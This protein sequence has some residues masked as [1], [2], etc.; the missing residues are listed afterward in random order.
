VRVLNDAAAYDGYMRRSTALSPAFTD[1][2]SV[3]AALQQARAFGPRSMVRGAVA[4]AAVAALQNQAFVAALRDAGNTPEHRDQMVGYILTNPVYLYGFKGSQE[5]AAL[6]QSALAPSALKLYGTGRIIRQSAYDIQKQ[7]WSK[8]NVTDLPGR[9]ASSEAAAKGE[10]P[11]DPDRLAEIKQAMAGASPLPDVAAPPPLAPP[12]TPMVAH[13]LQLAGIAAL[14]EAGDEAYDR[15]AGLLADD[16]TEAC[17]AAAKRN[18]HQCLAVAKPNYEDIFCTGQHGL[19][20]TG[21]CMAKA[22]GVEPPPEPAP[23]PPMVK[24]KPAKARLHHRRPAAAG[25]AQPH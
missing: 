19:R 24:T 13:A 8:V 3:S 18:F 11:A 16:D 17:L 25:S 2:A 22:A 10:M 9:L 14:G 5:A 7:S 4:Y 12:Y 15:L 6:A 20:D 23:P 1:A 21:A